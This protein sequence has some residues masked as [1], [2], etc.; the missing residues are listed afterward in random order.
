[1]VYKPK[2]PALPEAA[3]R[4]PVGSFDDDDRKSSIDS[5]PQATGWQTE[6]TRELVEQLIV[7]AKVGGFKKQ[8][9]LA[10]CV[11][12]ELLEWWLAEGMRDDADPLIQEL[13]ARFLSIQQRGSLHLVEVIDRAARAG[14][15]EAAV[16]LL[17]LREPLWRGSEKFLEPDTAPPVTSLKDRLSQLKDELRE[18]R[19]NP[20]GPLA[21]ALREA[22]FPLA[23]PESPESGELHALLERGK[24]ENPEP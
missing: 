10:C 15:W 18:A 2:P 6:L 17:K 9:A 8:A 20:I 4:V 16:T 7:A 3:V 5:L 14:E 13:S 12:P 19:L 24:L 1:M 23:E 11:K 21:D 22:G